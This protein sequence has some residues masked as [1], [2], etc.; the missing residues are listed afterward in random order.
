MN[1][2]TDARSNRVAG[3]GLN[4]VKEAPELRA[5][6]S[7]LGNAGFEP[8]GRSR[9]LVAGLGSAHGDDRAGWLV[10]EQLAAVDDLPSDVI[11]RKAAVPL[12]LIDWLDDVDT[13]HVCD[14][15]HA[16]SHELLVRQLIWSDG[17]LITAEPNDNRPALSLASRHRGGSHDYGLVEVL[18]L[19][20]ATGR[21]PRHVVVWAI[22]GS[23]FQPDDPMSAMT[24]LAVA[25]TTEL[26]RDALQ[27]TEAFHA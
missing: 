7:G 15:C 26:I 3:A 8:A 5:G 16:E 12:D 9:V 19:A 4:E 24:H 22:A 2:Q 1:G 6:S 20:K 21:L 10:A 18:Q 25:K 17:R 14:A 11:V 23:A 27:T 13:L